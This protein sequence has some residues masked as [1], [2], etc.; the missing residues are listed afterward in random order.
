MATLAPVGSL[1][2]MP[3][4]ECSPKSKPEPERGLPRKLVDR[5]LAR[6]GR[7][8][9]TQFADVLRASTLD[10][11]A[12]EWAEGLAGLQVDEIK[13]G[14]ERA[15]EACRWPPS[16]AEFRALCL[17]G[18]DDTVARIQRG[19]AYRILTPSRLL[20]AKPTDE[21]LA[22]AREHLDVMRRALRYHSGRSTI[23]ASDTTTEATA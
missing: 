16:I 22:R 19:E 10:D 3:G 1:L 4:G 9:P 14:I 12:H 15:R 5:L 13:R 18:A 11:L 6:F 21:Q 20:V 17:G 7:I 23:T 8:W 2:P